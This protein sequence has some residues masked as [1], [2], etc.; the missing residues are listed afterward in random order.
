MLTN[1]LKTFSETQCTSNTHVRVNYKKFYLTV[2]KCYT[3]H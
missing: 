3:S 1:K 2:Q